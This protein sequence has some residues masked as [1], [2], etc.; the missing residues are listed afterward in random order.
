MYGEEGGGDFV[1]LQKVKTT[2]Y[3]TFTDSEMFKY[4]LC[5]G[6][7]FFNFEKI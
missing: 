6:M 4:L 5:Y 7:L 1:C 3:L 2:L